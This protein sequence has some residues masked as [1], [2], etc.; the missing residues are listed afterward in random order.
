MMA[1]KPKGATTGRE[2]LVLASSLGT[3]CAVGRMGVQEICPTCGQTCMYTGLTKLA[4]T[5]ELCNCGVVE[6]EHLV[7]QL[8]HRGCLG[9]PPGEAG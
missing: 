9:A 4:Y 7:E 1:A 6:Y 8:W 3:R 2:F 5:F